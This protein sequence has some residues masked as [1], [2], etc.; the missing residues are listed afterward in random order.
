VTKITIREYLFRHIPQGCS[1]H[2]CVITGKK[3]GIGTNGGCNC[4]N[5]LTRGQL[6]ILSSHLQAIADK[7]IE[8]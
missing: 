5:D 6:Q 7:E 8:V 4:L 2:N 1:D 3:S